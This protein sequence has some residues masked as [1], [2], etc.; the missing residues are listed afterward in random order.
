[1]IG[2][3]AN[4]SDEDVIRE[5]FELF[6]TPW[7]FCRAD[8]SYEVVLCTRD[9]R[10]E[11]SA[12]VV[13]IYAGRETHFDIEHEGQVTN[14]RQDGR[15]LLY[16]GNRIPIYGESVTFLGVNQDFLSDECSGDSIGYVSSS[17]GR[18]LARI[19]YDLFDE[20]R[21]LLTQGQ[22]SLN[23]NIPTLEWHID[24][25]RNLITGCGVPLVEIPPAPDGYQFIVSLT[26][27]VDHPLIAKHK[28]DYTMVGFLY[29]A[30]LASL[31]KFMK[32]RLCLGELAANWRAAFKLP[33]VYLGLA[34][35]FWSE[36][37]DCY[38][39]LEKDLPSTF[40]VIAFKDYPG[41]NAGRRASRLRASRYEARDISNTIHKLMAAGREIGVHGVDAW[42]DSPRGRAE[43]DEIR[44]LTGVPEIGV[45]M[46]WLFYDQE[47]ALALEKAGATYDSTVGYN[48]TVGYRAG[49]MQAYK[50]LRARRMIE[51][52]LHVMD[53]ALFY[54]AY[55]HVSPKQGKILM[56]RLIDNAIQFGGCITVNWHDRSIFPER[57]WGAFYRDLIERLKS[58]RAWFSTA[59]Q[60]VAW[61][62]KR[63]AVMFETDPGESG[64][65]SAKIA[66]DDLRDLPPLCLRLHRARQSVQMQNDE[67][68][69]YIDVPFTEGVDTLLA[70]RLTHG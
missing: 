59:G 1:M 63:R 45:R 23:A 26:H 57:L 31:G 9:C 5:F 52:P 50:P 6:K 40:F 7:E 34:K 33:F 58:R 53:T 30:L 16:E 70:A 8:R 35:D 39:E 38:L 54:P 27:D 66:S 25:L 14:H 68:D 64:A 18:M 49:T 12:K 10:V 3:V 56:D 60:A 36:F 2:V 51:L 55:L 22:P 43:L 69:R 41:A 21:Y 47:S 19:G 13:L 61:F 46:H 62:R 15:V 28:W 17:T 42:L 44:N 29:R 37:G 24:L 11:R 67:I 48:D 65:I 20:I 4:P 32:G